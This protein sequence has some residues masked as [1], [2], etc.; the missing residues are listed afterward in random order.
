MAGGRLQRRAEDK[1]NDWVQKA[2]G[3]TVE[4]VERPRKAAPEEGA[5]GV[6]RA[7]GQGSQ[8]GRLAEAASAARIASVASWMGGGTLF[9]AWICHSRLMAKDY[10]RLCA[11]EQ[12]LV[13]AAMSRLIV[14]RLA[15]T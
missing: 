15:R 1:G 12:A 11:S 7:V 14:R 2:L 6:G 9:L 13:Y 3:W 8:E 5:R 4:L 10:E